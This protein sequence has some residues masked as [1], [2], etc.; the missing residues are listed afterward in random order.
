MTLGLVLYNLA[1]RQV[2]SLGNY[3]SQRQ[4]S[5]NERKR[6]DELINSA[7]DMLCRASGV[8]GFISQTLLPERERRVGSSSS[9]P[10][11][12]SQEMTG[13]LAEYVFNRVRGQD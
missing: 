5:E 2:S 8:F 6:L 4:T 12:L 11:D 13:A 1:E 3:E 7:A 9:L 10:I